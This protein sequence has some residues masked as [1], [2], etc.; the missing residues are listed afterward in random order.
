MMFPS[1]NRSPRLQLWI[2]K[3]SDTKVTFHPYSASKLQRVYGRR[4]F[5]TAG[6]GKA[7]MVKSA[8]LRRRL[9]VRDV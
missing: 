9:L 4:P 3:P 1:M 5:S 6:F 8:L 7:H 2:M